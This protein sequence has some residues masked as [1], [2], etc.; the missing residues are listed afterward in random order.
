[1]E[2]VSGVFLNLCSSRKRRRCKQLGR[3]DIFLVTKKYIYCYGLD[4]GCPLKAHVSQ[5]WSPA[6]QCSETGFGEVMD[7]EGSDLTME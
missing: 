1:M 3:D 4:L 7:C 6:Q 2:W 5:A